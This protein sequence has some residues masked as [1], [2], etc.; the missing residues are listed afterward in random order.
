MRQ[1]FED[2]GRKFDDGGD[3][4]SNKVIFHN[5]KGKVVSKK[6]MI[7]SMRK[8][9][10]KI[11]ESNDGAPPSSTAKQ[12]VTGHSLRRSGSQWLAWLGV[13]LSLI[14]LLGRWGSSVILRYVSEAPLE[15]I[16]ERFRELTTNKS[17]EEHRTMA[18]G[19]GIPNF[20][21]RIAAKTWCPRQAQF[22]FR[23]RSSRPSRGTVNFTPTC[24]GRHPSSYCRCA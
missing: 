18:L 4:F 15:R 13:E 5:S 17:I 23:L 3:E 14:Q 7:K 19:F 21:Q 1:I 10:E 6:L 2:A 22:G 24:V 11:S 20:Q 16:T 8:V 9:L 12:E